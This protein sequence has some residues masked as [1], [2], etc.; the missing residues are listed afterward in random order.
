MLVMAE[1][2]MKGIG[3]DATPMP[4]SMKEKGDMKDMGGGAERGSGKAGPQRRDL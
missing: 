2:R 4:A 1:G 3:G